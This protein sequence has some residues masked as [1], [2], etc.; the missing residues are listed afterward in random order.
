VPVLAGTVFA[1]AVLAMT[2]LAMNGA[3]THFYRRLTPF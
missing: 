2:V 3:R 1:G